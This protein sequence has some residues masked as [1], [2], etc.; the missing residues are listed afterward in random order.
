MRSSYRA[1]L[2]RSLVAMANAF[3]ENKADDLLSKTGREER[4]C[5]LQMFKGKSEIGVRFY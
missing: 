2:L 5:N 3:C 4:G 1:V